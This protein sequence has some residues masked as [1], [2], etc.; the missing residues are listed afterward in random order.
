MSDNALF[1]R[2][3]AETERA[4]ADAAVLSNVRERCERAA[5]S[6]EAMA[7]RAERTDTLRRQRE[8]ASRPM[9]SVDGD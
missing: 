9:A 7:A 6:W 5:T 2:K 1:Y 3:Q 4:N 8:A